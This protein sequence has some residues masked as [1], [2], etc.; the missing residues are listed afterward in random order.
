M[1]AQHFLSL[2][3]YVNV[4]LDSV[5]LNIYLVHVVSQCDLEY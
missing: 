2:M 5:S 4:L 3:L 1:K